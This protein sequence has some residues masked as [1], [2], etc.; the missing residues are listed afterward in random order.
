MRY[1]QLYQ[2]FGLLDNTIAASKMLEGTYVAP[3]GSRESVVDMLQTIE[4][5]AVGA[6]DRIFDIVI[7]LK[8]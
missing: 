4:E 5:V 1:G 7:T 8:D 6:K 2:D 3:E